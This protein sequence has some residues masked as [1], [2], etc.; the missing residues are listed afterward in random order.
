MKNPLLTYFVIMAFFQALHIFEE[1]YFEAYLEVGSLKKYLMVAS[2]LVFV[3]FFPLFLILQQIQWGYYL[4]F[5]PALLAMGNG[6][7]H[8]YGLIKT[9]TL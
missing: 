9:K 8:I 1:I 7:A 5:L 6:I 3:T 4:A 2:F